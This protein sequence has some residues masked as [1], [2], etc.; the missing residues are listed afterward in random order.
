MVAGY[1]MNAKAMAAPILMI[2]SR[3]AIVTDLAKVNFVKAVQKE[4][5][6]KCDLRSEKRSSGFH[7]GGIG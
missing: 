2:F 3:A 7:N 4:R 1:A 6:N 5:M